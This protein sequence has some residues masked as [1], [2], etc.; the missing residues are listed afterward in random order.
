MGLLDTLKMRLGMRS[1]PPFAELLRT[2]L[3]DPDLAPLVARKAYGVIEERLN[4]PGETLR[5]LDGSPV[6]WGEIVAAA[7]SEDG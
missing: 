3:Q 4:V 6:T 1:G 2:R 7:E 5:K